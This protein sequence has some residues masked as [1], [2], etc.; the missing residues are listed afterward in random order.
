M[1]FEDKHMFKF[2]CALLGFASIIIPGPIIPIISFIIAI[3][4]FVYKIKKAKESPEGFES[5]MLDIIIIVI[6]I[7]IDIAFFAMRVSIENDFNRKYNYSTSTSLSSEFSE[8]IEGAIASYMIQN[9]DLFS[10]SKNNVNK[11][12]S[13]FSSYLRNDLE[14]DDVTVQGNNIICNIGDKTVTFKITKNDIAYSIE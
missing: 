1:I 13:G 14:L 12:K 5:L 7:V 2:I 4:M 10:S 8:A 3:A 6:V 11:I 9:Y